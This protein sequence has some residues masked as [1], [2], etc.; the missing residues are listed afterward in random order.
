MTKQDCLNATMDSLG[1]QYSQKIIAALNCSDP[2]HFQQNTSLEASVLS[3]VPVKPTVS[4]LGKCESFKGGACDNL[5]KQDSTQY[6]DKLFP[7]YIPYSLN[8]DFLISKVHNSTRQFNILQAQP[9]GKTCADQL[10]RLTCFT[11]LLR[12]Q[13]ISYP[14][15]IPVTPFG[16]LSTIVP[17]SL[18]VESPCRSLCLSSQLSC[19][20]LAELLSSSSSSSGVDCEQISPIS[21]S[22]VYQP[23]GVPNQPLPGVS[24]NCLS[25][26]TVNKRTQMEPLACVSPLLYFEKEEPVCQA[27]CTTYVFEEDVTNRQQT[28][29]VVLAHL[30]L[31]LDLFVVATLSIFKSKRQFPNNLAWYLAMGSTMVALFIVLPEWIGREEVFCE[32]PVDRTYT[33]GFCAA[34]GF[35]I[36][37][38]AL[39]TV[40]WWF[41]LILTLFLTVV[42]GN[43]QTYKYEKYY[44]VIAWGFPLLMAIIT[45]GNGF[46]GYD[47][48]SFW[49]LFNEQVSEENQFALFYG[50]IGLFIAFGL[51]MVIWIIYKIIRI[52][53]AARGNARNYRQYFRLV[54]VCIFIMFVFVFIFAFRI[55]MRLVRED[56]TESVQE[57]VLCRGTTFDGKCEPYETPSYTLWVLGTTSPAFQ[58][59]L[60]FLFFGCTEE[61]F[62]LWKALL[63][64][65]TGLISDRLSSRNKTNSGR[66]G[67]EMERLRSAPSPNVSGFNAKSGATATAT[68]S[69]ERPDSVALSEVSG[70]ESVH[71]PGNITPP[72]APA[73]IAAKPTDAVD[74]TPTRDEIPHEKPQQ[75]QQPVSESDSDAGSESGSESDNESES[76]SSGLRPNPDG[77]AD[78]HGPHEDV[79][80]QQEDYRDQTGGGSMDL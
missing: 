68:Q 77:N 31:F 36:L 73:P 69:R 74:E 70:A 20:P 14:L 4:T 76:E 21:N 16:D 40:L 19:I 13:T 78:A 46:Y 41:A 30:S 66:T 23:D 28:V 17:V 29:V 65:D 6:F 8:Q 52:S 24:L 58:G 27:P 60:V 26:T 59:V 11:G 2:T 35:M 39:S 44:H 79:D 54:L 64:G 33:S 48:F 38:F 55:H 63:Q 15:A 53:K 5:M 42:L 51:V 45:A 3:D 80:A 1:C 43:K 57:N 32:T 61:N 49:C 25:A 71:A 56:V 34:Q 67:I 22:L 75:N 9:E 10:Y 7:V 72:S 47:G 62:R 12:C 50:W 37:M 18:P